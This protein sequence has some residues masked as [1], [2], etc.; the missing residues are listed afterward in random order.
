VKGRTFPGE[1]F[2]LALRMNRP[3]HST[4][5]PVTKHVALDIEMESG[6]SRKYEE[7]DEER[8]Q[9]EEATAFHA[10]GLKRGRHTIGPCF[11]GIIFETIR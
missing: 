7:D 11:Q 10:S 1:R 3:A 4:R 2:K 6:P 8:N 5:K 9:N